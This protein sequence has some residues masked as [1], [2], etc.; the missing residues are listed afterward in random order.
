[1]RKLGLWFYALVAGFLMDLCFGDPY[2]LPHPVRWIGSFIRKT[3]KM[4]RDM[5]PDTEKGQFF[6]GFVLVVVVLFFSTVIPYTLLYLAGKVGTWLVFLLET[7]MFYQILAVK[8]L[9][10]E[11]IKVYQELVKNDLP[12]ARKAVA[13]IVGRDTQNLTVEGVTKAAVETV[14]ENTSDG[15]VAPLF[16]M[17]LGGPALG[18]FYKAVNTM[19]SMVGYKNEKYLYFGRCA[20]KLDD[21][22]NFIPARLSAGLMVVSAFLCGFD[23]KNAWRIFKRDRQ[24]HD[25]PNSAQTEA[26]CAGALGIQLAGNAWYF[27]KLHEKPFIG[28]ALRPVEPE[29]IQ[30]VNRLLYMTA[31]LTVAVFAAVKILV[32]W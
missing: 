26:A 9:K 20:A 3:E 10:K 28:D 31:F 22:L 12:S 2:C 21:V 1:M 17:V 30:R 8:S 15:V 4:I 23:G 5:F 19:D 7:M 18:F 14:A 27:G 29:D 24:N 6:G 32:L 16:Y 25:S 13:R 11:S